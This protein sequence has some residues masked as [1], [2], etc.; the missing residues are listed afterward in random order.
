MDQAI[1]VA[2][3]PPAVPAE[4]WWLQPAVGAAIITAIVALIVGLAGLI[5]NH[6]LQQQRLATD[7]EISD[8]KSAGDIELAKR[9]FDNERALDDWKR[10][11]AFAEEILTDFYQAQWAISAIRNPIVWAGEMSGREGRDEEDPDLRRHLDSYYPYL[12]RIQQ[13][14][15]L[16]DRLRARRFR[17]VALFGRGADAPFDRIHRVIAEI[18]SAAQS[19]MRRPPLIETEA[20]QKFRNRMEAKIWEGL[21]TDGEGPDL[22]TVEVEEA[23]QLA[24]AN[25][26]PV[27]DAVPQ[28]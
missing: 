17:A 22:I 25:F 18:G 21:S 27:L 7:K 6:R 2:A 3:V 19:L 24:E 4:T 1:I 15:E 14:G 9:K 10:R 26:R 12:Q 13:H 28:S 23:I 8:R 5:L 20:N 16:L 11:V